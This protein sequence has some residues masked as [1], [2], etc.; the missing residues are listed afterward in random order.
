M[1]QRDPSTARR[2][3]KRVVTAS[4]AS[5]GLALAASLYPIP[6]DSR[7][8]DLFP[9]KADSAQ[10][11]PS[12]DALQ[13][14]LVEHGTGDGYSA[15]ALRA[16]LDRS[17]PDG[18]S[19]MAAI[20]ADIPAETLSEL[21]AIYGMP[22]LMLALNTLVVGSAP[23][24]TGG[25]HGAWGGSPLG[26]GH[27]VL[28]A[29]VMLLDFLG[30]EL[31]ALFVTR[32]PTFVATVWSAVLR[33]LDVLVAEAAPVAGATAAAA[34][35]YAEAATSQASV[36]MVS[37]PEP[38]PEPEPSYQAEA[39]SEQEFTDVDMAQRAAFTTP[40][41]DLT[42]VPV[43]ELDTEGENTPQNKA[44]TDINPDNASEKS[45]DPEPTAPAVENTPTDEPDPPEETSRTEPEN[46][47]PDDDPQGGG[48][49]E[50]DTTGQ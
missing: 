39:V 46:D 41:T 2:A 50:G 25:A 42:T 15:T 49:P 13:V 36:P 8:L 16:A 28:P 45:T 1:L 32:S 47:P 3:N 14:G 23:S 20:V 10:L 43:N 4:I 11:Q 37:D 22:N 27:S 17:L 48:A 24:M 12:A 26:S 29:L 7:L 40:R 35:P 34:E 33:S 38:T 5:V 44:V 18:D 19:A 6:G 31:P 30:G 9:P 21:V